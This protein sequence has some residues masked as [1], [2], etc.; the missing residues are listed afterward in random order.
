MPTYRQHSHCSYCGQRFGD[1]PWPRRCAVCGNVSFLNPIPVTI[2]LQPVDDGILVVRR[3]IEPRQ[4]LLALPGGYIDLGESWQEAGA[5]EMWEEA[6]VAIDP[7]AVHPFHVFS[8]ADGTLIVCGRAPDLRQVDL[9]P[10][11]PTPE[12]TERMVLMAPAELAF[13]LHTQIVADYFR[14]RDHARAGRTIH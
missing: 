9:P 11:Q 4:G 3:G 10:F 6:S 1:E 2:I 13:L 7:A 8:A 5:R 14:N 12:A